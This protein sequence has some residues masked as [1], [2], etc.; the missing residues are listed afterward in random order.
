MWLD[1]FW[2]EGVAMAKVLVIGG[3]SYDSVVQLKEFPQPQPGNVYSKSHHEMV[4]S[5]GSGKAMVLAK[6]GFH[7]TLHGVIGEDEYGKRIR[8]TFIRAG[9]HFIYDCDAQGTDRHLNLMDSQGQ[10]ITIWLTHSTAEPRLDIEQ[11][12]PLIASCDVLVLNII[13]YCRHLIPLAK[14]YNKKI[15][16]DIHD[17]DG[18]NSYHKDFIEAADMLFMSS[19]A[20]PDYKAFMEAMAQEKE[21]VVCTHGRNG[22]TALIDGDFYTQSIVPYPVADSNGAGDNFFTG[23]LYGYLQGYAP[24]KCLQLATVAGG[25]SATSLEITAPDLSR[26]KLE[27][28]WARFYASEGQA[29]R[30]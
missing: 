18:Q 22:A 1:K 14:K 6:L 9:V 25:L 7:T 15:W 26:D 12:E 10:R 4:G 19:D 17:Y 30:E 16:C 13:N 8:E 3:V 21:I 24:E 27:S 20:I 28:E 29:V 2:T 11:L 23:Y 5:T